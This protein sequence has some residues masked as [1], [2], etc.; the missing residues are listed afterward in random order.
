MGRPPSAKADVAAAMPNGMTTL[1]STPSAG[2][3]LGRPYGKRHL[4]GKLAAGTAAELQ[5]M[6]QMLNLRAAE[7]AMEMQTLQDLDKDGLGE[8]LT[9]IYHTFTQMLEFGVCDVIWLS[10]L[11]PAWLELSSQSTALIARSWEVLYHWAL[12][13]I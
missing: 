9:L 10:A 4:A 12:M 7:I 3:S 13:M 5:A 11:L 2:A 6:I 8:Q 1:T